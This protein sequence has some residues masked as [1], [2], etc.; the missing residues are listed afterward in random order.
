MW[1]F[2]IAAKGLDGALSALFTS[3]LPGSI[4]E[5]GICFWPHFVIVRS[6]TSLYAIK[7]RQKSGIL[8]LT[9]IQDF[10]NSVQDTDD[11]HSLLKAKGPFSDSVKLI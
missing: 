1:L 11:L 8:E 5:Q 3:E 7:I 2:V 6:D 10:Q 4:V 9:Y